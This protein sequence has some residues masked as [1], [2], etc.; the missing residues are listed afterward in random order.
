MGDQH[1]FKPSCISPCLLVNSVKKYACWG[2]LISHYSWW[3][4]QHQ[5]NWRATH[6]DPH[7]PRGWWRSTINP[8]LDQVHQELDFSLR[9]ILIFRIHQP[10]INHSNLYIFE[11]N[12]V[13]PS[14]KVSHV[15]H[16][17]YH[18]F[19]TESN[20]ESGC[21]GPPCF[22][23]IFS[24]QSLIFFGSGII[25]WC[26]TLSCF[27]CDLTGFGPGLAENCESHETLG[28][29]MVYIWGGFLSHRATP[30]TSSSISND[31]IFPYT[32]TIHPIGG[33]PMTMESPIYG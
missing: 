29:Q 9:Q 7:V 17:S 26:M 20:L 14:N 24:C 19:S 5:P 32:K 28:L 30:Q 15:L 11:H 25:G 18:S 12:M 33:T 4:Y 31:G 13:S 2:P 10:W 27:S 23:K 8:S 16:K 3:L 1:W 22:F 6:I 21:R